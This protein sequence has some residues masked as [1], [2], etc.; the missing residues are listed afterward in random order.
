MEEYLTKIMK[1]YNSLI[2]TQYLFIVIFIY[3]Y[4]YLDQLYLQFSYYQFS[5]KQFI[6]DV[7]PREMM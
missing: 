2:A 1:G 6:N 7:M 3:G 5:Y 4:L